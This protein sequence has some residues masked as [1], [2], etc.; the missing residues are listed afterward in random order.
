MAS[1]VRT[2]ST[3]DCGDI[4]IV[5]SLLDPRGGSHCW[6]SVSISVF[7][8]CRVSLVP[9]VIRASEWRRGNSRLGRHKFLRRIWNFVNGHI[10]VIKSP[11]RSANSVE[12]GVP[13]RSMN[14]VQNRFG[15][16]KSSV[17]GRSGRCVFS[18][19][20]GCRCYSGW[21]GEFCQNNGN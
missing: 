8:A 13:E 16:L 6:Y 5:R 17:C 20:F 10:D 9:F 2:S 19:A 15:M 4:G 18:G 7:F 3:D 12:K 1:G 14:H 11:S 21:H